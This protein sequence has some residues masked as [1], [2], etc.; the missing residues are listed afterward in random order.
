MFKKQGCAVHVFKCNLNVTEASEQ[1]QA[2]LKGLDDVKPLR[3]PPVPKVKPDVNSFQNINNQVKY[4]GGKGIIPP[5]QMKCNIL[6][7]RAEEELKKGDVLLK[8]N[9]CLEGIS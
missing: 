4:P 2:R 1:A 9:L 5:D 6:K 8:L 3:P 7:A